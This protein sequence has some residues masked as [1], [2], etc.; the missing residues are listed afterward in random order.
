MLWKINNQGTIFGVVIP[1]D[2]KTKTW[3]QTILCNA[4]PSKIVFI[5]NAEWYIW[6]GC[7]IVYTRIEV[8]SVKVILIIYIIICSKSC[9]IG[10]SWQFVYE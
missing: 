10:C 1:F 6:Y 3:K 9:I 2:N 8:Y 4:W 5:M 7:N